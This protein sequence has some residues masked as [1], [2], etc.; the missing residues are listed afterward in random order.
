MYLL[1]ANGNI[2]HQ[3][4]DVTDPSD[5]E[6]VV[7]V[8]Q[9]LQGTHKNFWE[10]D[11]GIAYLVSG[12][13]GWRTNRAT[14]IF[15]L[16]NP[17]APIHIRDYG[18]VG[19]EPGST[20]PVPTSLHGPISLGQRVYFGHGTS[21]N[22]IVQIVDRTKLLTGPPAPTPENLRFPVIAQ[23]NTYALGGLTRPSRSWASRCRSSASSRWAARAT[24][25]WW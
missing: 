22:G 12:I 7:D 18:L 14:Q 5:P 6:L 24:S 19:Q 20:G 16:S 21:S 23:H 17:E 10:C 3:V 1:R 2:G 15:D 8:V 4:W 25:S 9:G 11:T 13:P